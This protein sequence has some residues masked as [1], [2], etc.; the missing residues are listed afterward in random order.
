MVK[1]Y[2]DRCGKEAMTAY[3][4]TQVKWPVV[5]IR[6]KESLDQC[7]RVFD[8]CISCKE[9]LLSFLTEEKGKKNG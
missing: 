6:F 9:E 3:D 7:G 2:C 8:L 5:E 4:W 1:R